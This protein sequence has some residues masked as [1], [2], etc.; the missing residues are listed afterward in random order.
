MHTGRPS[1]AAVSWAAMLSKVTK[2]NTTVA[3]PYKRKNNTE[4]DP[5]KL[6][7][8]HE[9]KVVSARNSKCTE[10]ACAAACV[11]R[12][13]FCSS[14]L[15]FMHSLTAFIAPFIICKASSSRPLSGQVST[16]ANIACRKR[17][18]RVLLMCEAFF[19]RDARRSHFV[20]CRGRKSCD[21]L[22][23]A[24][25]ERPLQAVYLQH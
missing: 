20:V 18:R 16:F 21:L 1:I 8:Q 6:A 19:W 12:H 23:D 9:G 22:Q 10:C 2:C 14:S 4:L 5:G 7:P 24:L 15:Y 11:V 3:P 17:G 13:P 25:N